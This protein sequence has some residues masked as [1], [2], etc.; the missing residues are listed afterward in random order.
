MLS[1]FTLLA[2]LSTQLVGVVKAQDYSSDHNV[3]SLLGTWSTGS[4]G[5]LT[6]PVRL[7]LPLSFSMLLLSGLVY[8]CAR[9][10]TKDGRD[11]S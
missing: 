3:T 5:V 9:A 6:G 11:V 8:E 2:A 10:Q 4:G 1:L 7:L